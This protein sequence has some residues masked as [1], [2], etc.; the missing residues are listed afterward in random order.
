[1]GKTA[2]NKEFWDEDRQSVK[3]QADAEQAGDERAMLIKV[4][5]HSR[6]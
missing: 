2:R 1:M 3:L 6:T 4:P 5:P